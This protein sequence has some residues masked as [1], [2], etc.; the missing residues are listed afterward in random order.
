MCR[1]SCGGCRRGQ[2][3]SES[4]LDRE[5]YLHGIRDAIRGTPAERIEWIAE[6]HQ[7]AAEALGEAIVVLD[8]LPTIPDE[9]RHALL[10]WLA[11]QGIAHEKPDTSF[12]V[13]GVLVDGVDVEFNTPCDAPFRRGAAK[14]RICSHGRVVVLVDCRGGRCWVV[15]ASLGQAYADEGRL[16]GRLLWAY[17]DGGDGLCVM[18]VLWED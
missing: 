15:G 7:N 10:S 16:L 11:A 17:G 6:T 13:P 1:C 14:G 9:R 8:R 18:F 2:P 3:S 5:H 12:A 4:L